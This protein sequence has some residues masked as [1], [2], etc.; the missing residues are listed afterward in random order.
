LIPKPDSLRTRLL[1]C[2]QILIFVARTP[3]E[4]L[5]V[6]HS[7]TCLHQGQIDG[8]IADKDFSHRATV[9]V[10]LNLTNSNLLPDGK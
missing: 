2:C 6:D 8:A 4:I 3:L 10:F 9:F 7:R 5:A 1:F